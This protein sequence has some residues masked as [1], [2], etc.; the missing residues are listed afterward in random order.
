MKLNDVFAQEVLKPKSAKES[1][2]VERVMKTWKVTT[3]IE[4]RSTED[5]QKLSED[6]K[7]YR[8]EVLVRITEID[9]KRRELEVLKNDAAREFGLVIQE[10]RDREMTTARLLTLN[11]WIDKNNT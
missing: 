3:E 1:T 8:Q 10:I 11:E 5:L 9:E 7:S 4:S 2:E 6:L